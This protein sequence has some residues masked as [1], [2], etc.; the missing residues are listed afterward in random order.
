MLSLFEVLSSHSKNRDTGAL[1]LVFERSRL[2][3]VFFYKGRIVAARSGSSLGRDAITAYTSEPI[4]RQTFHDGV[5][6]KSLQKELP[7]TVELIRSLAPHKPQKRTHS[8]D[9]AAQ[10]KIIVD[11]LTNRLGPIAELIYDEEMNKASS[12]EGLLDRLEQHLT[13]KRE[14]HIFRKNVRERLDALA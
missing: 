2:L 3:Q 14:T 9:V 5:K 4:L 12:L 11:E 13:S 7:N 6:P 8:A 1:F 10:S